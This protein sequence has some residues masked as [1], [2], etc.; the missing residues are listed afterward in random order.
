MYQ[1]S[2][3]LLKAEHDTDAKGATMIR[4]PVAAALALPGQDIDLLPLV[5]FSYEWP[6]DGLYDPVHWLHEYDLYLESVSQ[7]S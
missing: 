2:V 1:E 3:Q 6:D 5:D 4:H 7:Y